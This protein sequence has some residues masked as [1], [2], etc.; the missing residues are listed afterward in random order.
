MVLRRIAGQAERRGLAIITYVQ[1]LGSWLESY[2][3]YEDYQ[4]P[5]GTRPEA[6]KKAATP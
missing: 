4:A 1:W 2:P 5:V 6:E 3:Y